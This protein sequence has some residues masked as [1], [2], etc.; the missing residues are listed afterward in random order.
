MD[1][2]RIKVDKWMVLSRDDWRIHEMHR[3]SNATIF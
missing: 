2:M 3:R 1:M